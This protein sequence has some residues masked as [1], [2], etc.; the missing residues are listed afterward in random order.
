MEIHPTAISANFLAEPRRQSGIAL[1]F[2]ALKFLRTSFRTLLPLILI[3]FVRRGG[4]S[5]DSFWL[6]IILGIAG[7]QL[8]SSVI[9]YFRFYYYA[10][11]GELIIEKGVFQKTRLNIPFERIQTINFNQNILHQILKV[12]E[13]KIDTA[14]SANTELSIE[15]LD[16]TTADA[17]RDFVMKERAQKMET[18]QEEVNEDGEVVSVPIQQEEAKLLFR[19]SEREL[20]KIGISENHVQTFFIILGFFFGW[21][22]FGDDFFD[23]DYGELAV[24]TYEMV[25]SMMTTFLLGVGIVM[26]ILTI[27]VSLVR[28]VIRYHRLSVFE[29]A[30]GFKIVAGLFNRKEQAAPYQK[31]QFMQWSV[32]PIQKLMDFRTI[33]LYQASS[34]AVAKAKA[35]PIPGSSLGNLEAILKNIFPEHERRGYHIEHISSLIVQRRV[36]FLGIVPALIMLAQAILSGEISIYI[37][38]ILWTPLVWLLAR[39]YYRGYEIHIN[40]QLLELHRGVFGRKYTILRLFKVQAVEL[41]Q[42]P[43][44]RRKGL[45]NMELHT[46]AGVVKIPYMPLEQARN[47]RD[48]IL[49]EVEREERVWM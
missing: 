28:T 17:I 40:D 49:Y 30:S 14:G 41:I 37:V 31:I 33:R 32:N 4:E 48:Y 21:L 26:M 18:M 46:A 12:Y 10:K 16:K 24:E 15:A 3:Y 39:R 13:V 7:F 36:L 25:G 34:M 11:D 19:R 27:I 20:L 9:S 22:Q 6:P 8:L 5:E 23:V 1:V 2:Y 38:A 42:S 45:A 29:S 43:F 47:I 44:Q 35:L